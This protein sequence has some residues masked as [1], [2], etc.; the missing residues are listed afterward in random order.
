MKLL[1]NA[2]LPK[3]LMTKIVGNSHMENITLCTLRLKYK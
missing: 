3:M 1:M 2:T